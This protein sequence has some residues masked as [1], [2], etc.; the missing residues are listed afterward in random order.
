MT[1]ENCIKCKGHIGF[2]N[3]YVTCNY[4]NQHQQYV[5]NKNSDGSISIVGCE[6]ENDPND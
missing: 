1:L 2:V 4:W 3:G 5:T 6:I